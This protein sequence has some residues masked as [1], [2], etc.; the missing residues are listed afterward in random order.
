MTIPDFTY[1]DDFTLSFRFKIDDN[2]GPL[3]QYVYS[4][5]DINSTNSVSVFINE[6]SHATN[7]NVLRTIIRD[8]G[9]S[10][11]NTA[12]EI[13]IAALIGDG[14]WHT[15]TVTADSTTGLVAFIDGTPNISDNTRGT[16]TVNPIGPVYLGAR[17]NL[18]V[19]RF[20]GGLL[21]TVQVYE[22]ALS[23]S[24]VSDLH[25]AVNVATVSITVG[26]LDNQ[27]YKV[28]STGDAGDSTTADGI[29]NTGAT[30]SE[31]DVECTLRAAI[32][33]ANAHPWPRRDGIR[34]ALLPNWATAPESGQSRQAPSFRISQALY[35]SRAHHSP[36]THRPRS[37]G[38]TESEPVHRAM[39]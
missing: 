16:G 3:F 2:S 12:L 26:A 15:Y 10:L 21:D 18:D 4:H 38:S 13:D 11:S 30:N 33:Q 8:G 37:S 20:Y 36:A 32:E 25:A 9:D 6:A 14:L 5:G 23:A 19:A 1:G 24:E 39:D 28:N 35:R 22:R 29:C 31:G 7:P 34:H 17:Q 27:E